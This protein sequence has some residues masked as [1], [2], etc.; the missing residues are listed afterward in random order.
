[1]SDT[2]RNSSLGAA[3]FVGLTVY[4]ILTQSPADA[5]YADPADTMDMD[6]AQAA[7]V[8]SVETEDAPEAQVLHVALAHVSTA[9]SPNFPL[10]TAKEHPLQPQE[11]PATV[12]VQ[13]STPTLATRAWSII[14]TNIRWPEMDNLYKSGDTPAEPQIPRPETR[15]TVNLP[16]APAVRALARSPQLF[17]RPQSPSPAFE[18]GHQDGAVITSEPKPLVTPSG[19]TIPATVPS[20]VAHTVKG[21]V[22]HLRAGPSAR[23]A[24]IAKVPEGGMVYHNGIWGNWSR[25]D[26]LDGDVA[27]SGWMY[28]K[29]LGSTKTE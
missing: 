14:D 11:K 16:T 26:F 18:F 24:I 13:R 2:E 25:V 9:K 1:M 28:S 15:H 22:V 17:A 3:V 27:V 29:Y 7:T 12:V 8:L 5:E 20:P 21:D 23:T 4:T 6:A 19:E 10:E